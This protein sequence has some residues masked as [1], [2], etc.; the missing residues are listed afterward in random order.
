MYDFR[1]DDLEFYAEPTIHPKGPVA[2]GTVV[3]VDAGYPRE[4][5]V[6]QPLLA[7][8]LAAAGVARAVGYFVV[9]LLP[10]G[11]TPGNVFRNWKSLR[12]GPEYLVTPMRYRDKRGDLCEVEIH[13]YLPRSA[14][15]PE[16]LLR[17]RIKAQ[18]DKELPPR[19]EKISNLTTGQVL[20]PT[21]PT[22]WSHLGPA[23]L[24]QSLL[25]TLVLVGLAALVGAI[26]R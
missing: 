8:V 9:S 2:S 5:K 1:Y 22:L 12:K 3:A 24:L 10:G 26:V 6:G 16:D 7:G 11:V 21:P 19:V 25:G 13:G 14:L 4:V 20:H 18:R 17:M 15:E 23:L